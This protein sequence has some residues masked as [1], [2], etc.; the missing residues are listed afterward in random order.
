MLKQ[1]KKKHEEISN[2][3]GEKKIVTLESLK[4]L[5]LAYIPY[6]ELLKEGFVAGIGWAFGVTLGF[7]II[8]TLI[9]FLFRQ[10]GGLPVIGTWIAN[11]VQETQ[12][13]LLLRNPLF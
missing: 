4:K 10:L 13:Q 2:D 12:N 1:I 8:S 11:I 6:N 3:Q 5:K 7:V 9:I